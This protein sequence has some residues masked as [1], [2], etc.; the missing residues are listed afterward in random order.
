M[1]QRYTGKKPRIFHP[2][3]IYLLSHLLRR[4]KINWFMNKNSTTCL[5]YYIRLKYRKIKYVETFLCIAK[6]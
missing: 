5:Y 3:K 6:I 1:R 2:S 4:I